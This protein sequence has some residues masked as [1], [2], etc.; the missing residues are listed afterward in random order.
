MNYI[1][2]GPMMSDEEFDKKIAEDEKRLKRWK[3]T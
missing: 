2:F 1:V 3:E